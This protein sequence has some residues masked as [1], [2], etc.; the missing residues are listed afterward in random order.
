LIRYKSAIY[1]VIQ[2]ILC[3]EKFLMLQIMFA[4]LGS[5]AELLSLNMLVRIIIISIG[6]DSAVSCTMLLVYHDFSLIIL[7]CIGI[8]ACYVQLSPRVVQFTFCALLLLMTLWNEE[9]DSEI[10]TYFLSL[11]YFFFPHD[12]ANSFGRILLWY[13]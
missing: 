4:A 8:S 13:G 3:C 2:S 10:K 5:V 12:P 1:F 6:D 7:N 11:Q 9:S